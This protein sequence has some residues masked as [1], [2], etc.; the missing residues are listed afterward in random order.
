MHTLP[1]HVNK[2][3][4]GWE[5]VDIMQKLID[6]TGLR[7]GALIVQERVA[8][9]RKDAVWRCVCTCG[10]GRTDIV[11]RGVNLRK[12]IGTCRSEPASSE[13]L[14]CRGCGKAIVKSLNKIK[15]GEG[16]YCSSLCRSKSQS[17]ASSDNA[18]RA[19][20]SKYKKNN[21]VQ[22]KARKMVWNAIQLGKIKRGLCEVCGGSK[23]EAHHCD[24]AKPLDVMW[25]CNKHHNEWHK[26]NT[27]IY[28]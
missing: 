8:S 14:E 7:V 20:E 5:L 24:Y 25:L 18:K 3:P 12:G 1:P 16:K 27:P 9:K 26:N 4:S 17:H 13:T 2:N 10:C 19:R 6:I 15:R 21:P 22:N 23:V 11:R 28:E